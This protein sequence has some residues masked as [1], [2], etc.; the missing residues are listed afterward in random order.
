MNKVFILLISLLL[1]AGC[2]NNNTG[3]QLSGTLVNNPNSAS[4]KVNTK[5]LPVM[6][7]IEGS[8]DF[9]RI[10]QGEKVSYSFRFKNTGKSDLIIS[11][12]RT[13]C[14]CTVSEYPKTPVK[15]GTENFIQ[16]TFNSQG[17]VGA[18]NK[19]ITVIANTQPNTQELSI[20]ALII[21]PEN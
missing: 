13:S 16:V 10:N 19:I 20:K 4:G 5:D 1:V 18:Q 8:H 15:P 14:G 6:T 12:V 21:V 3:N 11:D 7:F 17:K 2:K 9:G